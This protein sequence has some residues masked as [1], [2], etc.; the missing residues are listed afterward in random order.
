MP[1]SIKPLQRILVIRRDNIGDLICTLPLINNLRE[2]YPEAQIDLLVNSYNQQTIE[3]QPEIDSVYAYT[4]AKHRLKGQSKLRVYWQRLL[5]LLRLRHTRYDI[6]ILAGSRFSNH[7]LKLAKVINAKHIMAVVPASPIINCI[8]LSILESFDTSL[9]EVEH[10]LALLPL[11]GIKANPTIAANLYANPTC[12]KSWQAY[13]AEQRLYQ[14]SRLTIGIHISAR[15]PSQRWSITY[16]IDLI[17]RLHQ[18]YACQF[19]LFWAQGDENNPQHPGD[20]QKAQAILTA[21][22]DLPVFPFETKQLRDLIAGIDCC[23]QFICSDGGAMHIAAGL[24]KPLLCFF[25]D[26]NAQQWYPWQV[27]HQLLQPD[28]K[29]VKDI[30][31][32]MAHAAFTQLQDSL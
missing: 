14:K 31:P 5:L 22:S 26:S 30:S 18:S 6:S 24:G 29:Q 11:L 17:Q 4:K 2:N 7:A 25:G 27:T 3:Q 13:L 8:D 1:H 23:D 10:C 12:I 20:N 32:K 9:H 21:V 15:K 16:F 19:I 28:S